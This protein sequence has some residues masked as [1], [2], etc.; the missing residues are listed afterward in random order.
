MTGQNL[1]GEHPA[2][3][4]IG[5]LFAGQPCFAADAVKPL[6]VTESRSRSSFEQQTTTCVSDIKYYFCVQLGPQTAPSRR[7]APVF[8][9]KSFKSVIVPGAGKTGFIRTD[10]VL[11]VPL[12]GRY[13]QPNEECGSPCLGITLEPADIRS[14]S[15]LERS[16]GA[17]TSSIERVSTMIVV[18]LKSCGFTRYRGL[19][20]GRQRQDHRHEGQNTAESEGQKIG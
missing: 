17:K 4:A 9:R 16:I 1:D 18:N 19:P 15:R 20:P 14:I 3:K 10:A 6:P 11:A 2:D 7:Q 8:P 12:P 5:L 13:L